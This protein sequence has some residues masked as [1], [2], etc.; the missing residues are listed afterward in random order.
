MKTVTIRP[1]KQGTQDDLTTYTRTH[2]RRREKK[3]AV[4]VAIWCHRHHTSARAT[5]HS[6]PTDV[7]FTANK[8][9]GLRQPCQ[10]VHR[11]R[12]RPDSSDSIDEH[13]RK[14]ALGLRRAGTGTNHPVCYDPLSHRSDSWLSCDLYSRGG[15]GGERK[16]MK[17]WGGQQ[18]FFLI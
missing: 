15:G 14:N 8:R 5:P 13:C 17:I 10:T 18:P 9:W 3:S 4:E 16:I 6:A 12:R 2:I 7:A 11:T 1:Q